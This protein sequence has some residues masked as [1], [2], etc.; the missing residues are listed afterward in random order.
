MT[1]GKGHLERKFF[2]PAGFELVPLTL[3]KSR[4]DDVYRFKINTN[5]LLVFHL[6]EVSLADFTPLYLL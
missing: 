1:R 6:R 3:S 5:H 4:I 2:P